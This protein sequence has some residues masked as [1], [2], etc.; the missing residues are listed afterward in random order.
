MAKFLSKSLWNCLKIHIREC[1]WV[2]YQSFAPCL[3]YELSNDLDAQR[4]FDKHFVTKKLIMAVYLSLFLNVFLQSCT[5]SQCHLTKGLLVV[6]TF[7]RRSI[8]LWHGTP[9]I[10]SQRKRKKVSLTT[11]TTQ[12]QEH[13]KPSSSIFKYWHT[14]Q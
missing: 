14:Y 3:W 6:Y 9:T 10:N 5:I 12:E 1:I 13:N 2:K 4:G 7:V 8:H 11:L